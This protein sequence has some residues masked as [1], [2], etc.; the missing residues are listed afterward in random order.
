[1]SALIHPIVLPTATAGRQLHVS[2][3]IWLA[4]VAGNTNIPLRRLAF[5]HGADLTCTELVSTRSIAMTGSIE[6][7]RR[8]LHSDGTTPT[9]I[10]L[11]GS[12][13]DEFLRALEIILAQDDFRETRIFDIN[14]GCPVP[15]VVKTGAGAALMLDPER[16]AAIV[17]R[18]VDFLAPLGHLVT[19]KVRR[20]FHADDNTVAE[21]TRRL[22][23]SGVSAIT[24][25]GRTRAQMYSGVADIGCIAEAV[26]AVRSEN[27]AVPVIGNGDIRD[28]ASA[29]RM[30]LATG[31]DGIM[32]GRAALGNP[33][34][35]AHVKAALADVK[36]TG[37]PA[38]ATAAEHAAILAAVA[39][40]D[41]ENPLPPGPSAVSSAI[42]KL[43]RDMVQ[44]DG[45]Y[46]ATRE[47]RHILLPF[48]RHSRTATRLR[49]RAARLSSEAELIEI[50]KEYES[51]NANDSQQFEL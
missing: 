3:N 44:L 39:A 4:P 14:M 47:F 48:F 20:G 31:C 43:Y 27:P 25:H 36:R 1:M 19:A 10:Q 46:R 45:N 18:T 40:Y 50:L 12:E 13:P 35:F 22:A 21:F 49:N 38:D 23:Q 8:Y 2:G 30:F 16:A 9:A 28:A 7:S 11:F 6:A 41:R 24:V 42:M 33:W 29:A 5:E 15:K 51:V 32:I 37:D 17:R 26:S 34:I